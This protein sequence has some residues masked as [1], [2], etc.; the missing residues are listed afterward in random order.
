[1]DAKKSDGNSIEM[2]RA[3]A[4]IIHTWWISQK[5]RD[6]GKKIANNFIRIHILN[7]VR[8]MYKVSREAGNLRLSNANIVVYAF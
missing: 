2:G 6:E 3:R 5:Q 8:K 1:M 7:A 4:L